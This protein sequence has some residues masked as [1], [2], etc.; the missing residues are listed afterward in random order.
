MPSLIVQKHVRK[1][2]LDDLKERGGLVGRV[3]RQHESIQQVEVLA[4]GFDGIDIAR[5]GFAVVVWRMVNGEVG[6]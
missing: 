6:L 4:E 1:T 2:D 5:H 3:P